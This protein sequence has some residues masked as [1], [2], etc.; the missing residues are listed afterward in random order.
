MSCRCGPIYTR[1]ARREMMRVICCLSVPTFKTQW[2]SILVGNHFQV[3][4]DYALS[5]S[6]CGL[7]L[8]PDTSLHIRW[9][10]RNFPCDTLWNRNVYGSW[11]F[12]LIRQ[13]YPHLIITTLCRRLVPYNSVGNKIANKCC[14]YDKVR[15]IETAQR[16]RWSSQVVW[17]CM[18]ELR[19][20][21]DEFDILT[22]CFSDVKALE[23]S[24]VIQMTPN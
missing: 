10:R 16:T 5:R 7:S 11:I 15:T 9:F 8:W 17:V 12:D 19:M 13:K 1:E 14:R 2:F 6:W 20:L 22:A 24:R 21:M 23:T 18:F 3:D 4:L